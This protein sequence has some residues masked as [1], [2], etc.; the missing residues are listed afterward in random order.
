MKW[1]FSDQASLE[2]E[3]LEEKLRD[4]LKKKKKLKKV[5]VTCQ[6]PQREN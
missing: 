4:F 2:Y 3:C 6:L 5:A 1:D